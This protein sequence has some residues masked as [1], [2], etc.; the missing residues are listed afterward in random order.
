MNIDLYY[1]S[2]LF[3]EY[4]LFFRYEGKFYI[5][6]VRIKEDCIQQYQTEEIKENYYEL[7]EKGRALKTGYETAR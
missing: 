1:Y 4:R 3:D 2:P 7:L 5:A 6:E